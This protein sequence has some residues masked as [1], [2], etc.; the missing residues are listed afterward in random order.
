MTN[1]APIGALARMAAIRHERCNGV[2]AAPNWNSNG[3]I[4]FYSGAGNQVA[5]RA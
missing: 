3:S 1:G 4:P 5:A 2:D